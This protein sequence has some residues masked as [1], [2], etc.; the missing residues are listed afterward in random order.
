MQLSMQIT[1]NTGRSFQSELQNLKHQNLDRR[2]I[3]HFQQRLSGEIGTIGWL[4]GA[5]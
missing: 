1:A 2:P 3:H 5:S 4:R